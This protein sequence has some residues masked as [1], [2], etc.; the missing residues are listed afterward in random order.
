MVD[1]GP[2]SQTQGV[3]TRR[4]HVACSRVLTLRC[5]ALHDRG[6]VG[7]WR[8][9]GFGTQQNIIA[10]DRTFIAQYSHEDAHYWSAVLMLMKARRG[11]SAVAR[12]RAYLECANA[13]DDHE[14]ANTLLN[15]IGKSR[16]L[17][18]L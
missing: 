2:A 9:F 10:A 6:A 8:E 7:S 4:R 18:K 13:D 5:L 15:L 3:R 14:A 17:K 12:I 11:K 16:Y 1:P